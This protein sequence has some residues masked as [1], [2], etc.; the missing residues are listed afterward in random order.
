MENIC[1]YNKEYKCLKVFKYIALPVTIVNILIELKSKKLNI[2]QEIILK[3]C[4]CNQYENEKI[5]E[6][7]NLDDRL[8]N[9]IKNE[10]ESEGNIENKKITFKGEKILE[11]K[12]TK[13]DKKEARLYYNN[14]TGEYLNFIDIKNEDYEIDKKIIRGNE[15]E[16]GTIGKPKKIKVFKV[17]RGNKEI[18]KLEVNTFFRIR[19]KSL[20][21]LKKKER[22]L[23]NNEKKENL[24]DIVKFEEINRKEFNYLLMHIDNEG[25]LYNPFDVKKEYYDNKLKKYLLKI[26]ELKENLND[27]NNIKNKPS[28]REKDDNK[29]EIKNKIR[30]IIKLS[31]NKLEG[32]NELLELLKEFYFLDEIEDKKT[33]VSN[34]YKSFVAVL[35]EYYKELQNNNIFLESYNYEGFKNKL[36]RLMINEF[37]LEFRNSYLKVNEKRMENSINSEVLM[38]L[39]VTILLLEQE[40]SNRKLFDFAKRNSEFLE[41]LEKLKKLRDNIDHSGGGY[42]NINQ[43]DVLE[44]GEL[45]IKFIEYIFNFDFLKIH[46]TQTNKNYEK[47]IREKSKK[48]LEINYNSIFESRFGNEILEIQY[49]YDMFKELKHKISKDM[50]MKKIGILLEKNLKELEEYV[51]KENIKLLSKKDKI[52]IK[53]IKS[54]FFKNSFENLEIKKINKEFESLEENSFKTEKVERLFHFYKNGTLNTYVTVLLYS[55]L[56]NSNFLNKLLKELPEFF[57]ECFLVS[58]YRGHNGKIDID[59]DELNSLI[60]NV[61]IIQEK[62]IKLKGE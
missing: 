17:E 20:S 28:L 16:I 23:S 30:Q 59:E 57:K 45:I 33:Y 11:D 12:I 31:S 53:D 61:Y 42:E 34:I 1:Y 6:V 26:K 36:E 14:F 54:K 4:R 19:D 18:D 32:K 7:L 48:L 21:F 2:F 62:Y 44:Y 27:E 24:K 40:S 8:I 25:N 13:I 35:K 50:I 41:K 29:K 39:L 43:S 51:Y 38:D 5:K 22:N 58:K 56:N 10:L 15:I 60:E 9:Y 3:M 49:R 55:S 37:K 46:T 47:N 52:T